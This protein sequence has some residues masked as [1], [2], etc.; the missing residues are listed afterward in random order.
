MEMTLK[1]RWIS[2]GC[3]IPFV[4]TSSS[5]CCDHLFKWQS[6]WSLR[7]NLPTGLNTSHDAFLGGGGL[8]FLMKMGRLRQ[9]MSV[10]NLHASIACSLFSLF[11]LTPV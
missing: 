3:S 8:V 4:D 6:L 5:M 2:G 9:E 11:R 7:E 10:A 1:V